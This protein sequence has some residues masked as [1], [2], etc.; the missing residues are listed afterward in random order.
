MKLLFSGNIANS[1]LPGCIS[2][3]LSYLPDMWCKSSKVYFLL[4][5]TLPSCGAKSNIRNVLIFYELVQRWLKLSG[6]LL[7]HLYYYVPDN[8]SVK[9]KVMTEEDLI[10]PPPSLSGHF[11]GMAFLR[12]ALPEAYVSSRQWMQWNVSLVSV[13]WVPQRNTGVQTQGYTA[14][15]TYL[16][17]VHIY[18]NV[19]SW[20]LSNYIAMWAE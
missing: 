5:N 13:S 8:I 15:Q 2:L 1:M 4:W 20:I 7:K 9:E 16:H 18:S 19:H 14:M 3:C 10:I 6:A 11:M 17:N 12:I